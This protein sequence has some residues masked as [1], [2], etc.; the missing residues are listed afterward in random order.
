MTEQKSREPQRETEPRELDKE[1][2][3]DLDPKLDEAAQ[4]KGGPGCQDGTRPGTR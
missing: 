1:T 3:E 4:L 2:L